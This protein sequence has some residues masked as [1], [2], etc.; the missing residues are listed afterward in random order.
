MY[1]H[2]SV[3]YVYHCTVVKLQSTRYVC[4]TNIC[5]YVRLR[6]PLCVKRITLYD[7]PLWVVF[8]YGKIIVFYHVL[9]W[10]CITH[11]TP[12]CTVLL[13]CVKAVLREIEITKNSPFRYTIH[14]ML[15]H[16]FKPRSVTDDNKRINVHL[17]IVRDMPFYVL[18]VCME[19]PTNVLYVRLQK[20]FEVIHTPFWH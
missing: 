3:S 7:F 14:T 6:K 2:L 1:P 4:R 20:T 13:Q 10:A 19:G 11:V 17:C 15:L 16:Y 8:Y 5:G 18:N 12:W 9:L